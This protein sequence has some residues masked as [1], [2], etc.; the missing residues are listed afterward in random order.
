[1]QKEDILESFQKNAVSAWRIWYWFTKKTFFPRFIHPF[2]L[3]PCSA[4]NNAK[5]DEC[6]FVNSGGLYV[7][8]WN[9]SDTSLDW[10]T[11]NK[12]EGGDRE[13]EGDMVQ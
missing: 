13:G 10:Q 9:S 5:I 6:H 8:P 12:S 7:T 2:V 11:A 3:Q 1:M 4:Q